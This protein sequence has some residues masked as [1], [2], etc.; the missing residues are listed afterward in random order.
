MGLILQYILR[1]LKF[2]AKVGPY[3]YQSVV[4]GK[5][6]IGELKKKKINPEKQIE[7]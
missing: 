7:K 3:V 6:I 4:F 5:K 2:V 1:G